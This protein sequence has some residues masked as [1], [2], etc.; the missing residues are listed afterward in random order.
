MLDFTQLLQDL[1]TQIAEAEHEIQATQLRLATLRGERVGVLRVLGAIQRPQQ[2]I[3]T[4]S[5]D[6]K[7]V[8]P[9]DPATAT[10]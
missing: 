5:E 6:R 8:P 7:E 2:P 3:I 1:D 9:H 10:P 4:T